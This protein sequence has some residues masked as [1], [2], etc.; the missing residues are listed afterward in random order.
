MEGCF[1]GVLQDSGAWWAGEFSR[2]FV[3]DGGALR[4]TMGQVSLYGLPRSSQTEPQA[5]R[6]QASMDRPGGSFWN[7]VV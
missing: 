7:A 3:G 6:D 2:G 5:F 4:V 1:Q